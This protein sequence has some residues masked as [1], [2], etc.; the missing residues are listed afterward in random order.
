MQDT[1]IVTAVR[2]A[3]GKFGGSL[4]GV[5]LPDLGRTVIEAAV[6]RAGV[7]KDRI[8]EVIMG[9]V[10][11]AGNDLNPARVSAVGAGLPDEVPAMT[12]NKACGSG[13]KAI[14]LADQAIRC[15]D[16]AVVLA[17]GMENMNRIPYALLDARQGY[18]MGN[19]KVVDLLVNGLNCPMEKVHMGVT[20]EEVAKRHAISRDEQDQFAAGSYAKA[21]AAREAGKFDREI[22]PVSIPQRKGD[23]VS[24][25]TDEDVVETPLETLAK[26]RPAFVKENGTVTAGN[27]SGINDGAAVTL[28]AGE[29]AVSEQGLKPLARIVGHA[30]AGLE[31]LVMGL[32]PARA[33]PRLLKK[34][35]WNYGDVDL[36]ELNEAFAAQ[37]LGVLRECPEI[38]PEK[39]NVHG[40]AVALGHPVGASG[41]RVV[42]TLIHALQDRKQTRGVASLCIGGGMGIAL[43]LELV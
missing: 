39:V 18:R 25:S 11:Q 37:S 1:F 33:I 26:L 10:L 23:P 28:V 20:A 24:F 43:A 8:D 27:A 42:T 38:D 3:I 21:V 30:S 9:C 14:A 6:E 13:L 4:A 2:T 19:G 32:G 29:K 35:G 17:G 15:E 40:G 7:G 36:W 12:I 16:A 5:P 22:V 31:P 34:I 41:A